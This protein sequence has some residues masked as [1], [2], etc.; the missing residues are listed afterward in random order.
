MNIF[1]LDYDIEKCAAYHN[2]K[3][4][5]KMIL[6]SA[7]MLCTTLNLQ[8]VETPYRTTHVNHPCAKWVR[9]SLDNW[10]WAR[11]LCLALSREH[12]YR[13]DPKREHKSATIVRSLPLP[14]LPEIGLTTFAQA[15][16]NK[17]R[18]DDTVQAYRNYYIGD[19]LGIS[20]WKRRGSP[21]WV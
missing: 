5:I 19:K 10:T 8:G 14:N 17:Y 2:D 20:T 1:V 4:V 15:M 7:Q 6:E 3:H 13:Y 12:K 16:P 11:D 18:D 21:Y 9:E